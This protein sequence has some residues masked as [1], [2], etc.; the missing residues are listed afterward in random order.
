MAIERP[1][2][3]A[4]SFDGGYTIG[5]IWYNSAIWDAPFELPTGISY[6]QFIQDNLSTVPADSG[7]WYIKPATTYNMFDGKASGAGVMPTTYGGYNLVWQFENWG[8]NQ[9]GQEAWDFYVNYA[10]DNFYWIWGNVYS[11]LA[12][13]RF[14]GGGYGFFASY[15]LYENETT[16]DKRIA[17]STHNL[18][19]SAD[20]LREG[21]FSWYTSVGRKEGNEFYGATGN[22]VWWVC[23]NASWN[24]GR[25]IMTCSYATSDIARGWIMYTTDYN[26]ALSDTLVDGFTSNFF[27]GEFPKK[28]M[29]LNSV[30]SPYAGVG[31]IYAPHTIDL[32]GYVLT[33]G[34]AFIGSYDTSADASEVPA[35]SGGG[36]GNYDNS[37]DSIGFPDGDQFTT[38]ALNSGLITVFNPTKANLIDFASFLYSDSITDA[39]ANQLKRLLANPLDYIIGLNIAHFTPSIS[40]AGTI[41]FGGVS[42]GV[43]CGIVSPQFQFLDCGELSV[44]E[45]TNSFQDYAL[46]KVKIFLPYCGTY[47][48]SI[49][50][51]MGGKI[52]C[53][54]VIDCLSGSCV[55][56]LKITRDRGY[57]GDA[58]LNSVMY[59]Y[60]GNC[61]TSVPLTSGDYKSSIGALLGV[62]SSAG[63][64]GGGLLTGNLGAVQSGIMGG[65]N[66][67]MNLAPDISRIGNYSS[68]FGYMQSQK[69]FLILERPIAS[70]PSRYENYYGRPIYDYR[71]LDGCDGYTEVDT[72]TLWTDKFDF[73]T[74]EEEEMLKNILNSGGIYIDHT[75][76]YNDY[77]PND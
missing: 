12:I 36:N 10:N 9:I 6:W 24:E 63:S 61:F 4:L 19:F 28:V 54:Y 68:N 52:W 33:S 46:S 8:Y 2:F 56:N 57:A 21:T 38:D 45:Q 23:R 17:C 41:N 44:P 70:I 27:G 47:E 14:S 59:S 26:V 39:V 18:A 11:G 42:S 71:T 49:S 22:G 50:E 60:T 69:P 65:I 20:D 37:S 30:Q 67:A 53:Q 66:S 16:G 31:E 76:A 3:F 34:G 1:E 58:S 15:G 29:A 43:S 64:I 35:G 25:A 72:N 13:Y 75:S 77:D 40:G 5:D 48:L 74:S 7:M 73:I 32:D 62:A 51:V 55:A